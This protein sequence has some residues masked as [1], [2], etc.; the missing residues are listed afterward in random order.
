MSTFR[1]TVVTPDKQLFDSQVSQIT[2]R[3]TCGDVGILK[4]HINYL[5]PLSIGAMTII[6]EDKTKRVA[7]IAGGMIQTTGEATTVLTHTC[8]W[9]DEIDIDRAKKAEQRARDYLENPTEI[10]TDE[11]AMLKLRRALNRIDIGSQL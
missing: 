9:A 11:I 10:H 4:G 3:T 6:M 1:L 2:V 5:A 7:A 8:E